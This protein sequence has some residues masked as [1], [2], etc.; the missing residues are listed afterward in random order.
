M[1]SKIFRVETENGEYVSVRKEDGLSV[2]HV[3]YY[4]AKFTNKQLDEFVN[5]LKKVKVG[6]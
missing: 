1:K 6:G 2:V 5:V 3:G 4:E